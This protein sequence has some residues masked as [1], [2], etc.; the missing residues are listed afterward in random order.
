[1]LTSGK[2]QA[3]R[4]RAHPAAMFSLMGVATRIAERMGLHRDG[5]IL[6]L[7][8]L[9]SEER[10]RMWWQLQY[11]ELTVAN[12]VGTLSPSVLGKWDSK[13]PANIDDDELGP[14][15]KTLP[16]QRATLTSMSNCL[17]KY[18]VLQFHRDLRSSAP[19][20]PSFGETTTMIDKIEE[21]LR[22]KFV[23]HCEL[24]N[25]LHVNLHLGI[26]QVLVATRR[27]MCQPAFV[28]AK[29]SDMSRQQRDE[30]LQIGMKNLD[31]CI[32]IQTSE[33]LKGFKWHNNAFFPWA[34][35]KSQVYYSSLF[36][37]QPLTM[38]VQS[39]MSFSRPITARKTPR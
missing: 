4:S 20:I 16:P 11:M 36:L 6:G 23:Q 37:A 15:T 33:P 24:L 10:R 3:I 25:P 12:Q 31:Y 27:L 8:V 13:M 35:C 7:S 34:A 38:C 14:G 19:A 30:L 26:C 32:L 1:M 17:W 39:S 21:M 18:T 5:E 28:N 29:I 9:R 22:V 2:Q